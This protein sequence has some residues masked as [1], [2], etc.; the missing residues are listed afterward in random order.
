MEADVVNEK[1]LRLAEV[2]EH[3]GDLL[4]HRREAVGQAELRRQSGGADFENLARLEDLIA[5]EAVQRGEETERTGAEAR[6]AAGDERAGALPRLGDAH[7]GER[8]Q[9]GADGRAAQAQLVRQLALGGEAVAGPQRAPLDQKRDVVHDL[10]GGLPLE[11][12]GVGVLVDCHW[13]DQFSTSRL[14]C[15]QDD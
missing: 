7:R 12:W 1:C 8:V 3:A 6:R 10:V 13:L 2:G 15:Q 5:R 14:D 11:R 9:A 4:G